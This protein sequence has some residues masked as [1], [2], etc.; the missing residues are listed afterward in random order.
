[1]MDWHGARLLAVNCMALM[2]TGLV[3]KAIDPM[4]TVMLTIY[5]CSPN[6]ETYGG[7]ATA[8]AG[9]VTNSGQPDTPGCDIGLRDEIELMANDAM[10]L[11]LSASFLAGVLTDRI[12]DTAPPASI[13]RFGCLLW[14]LGWINIFTKKLPLIFMGSLF[15]GFAFPLILNAI[16]FV[17]ATQ[18]SP[19]VG[20]SILSTSADS[21]TALPLSLSKV[22]LRLPFTSES[23]R[24]FLILGGTIAAAVSAMLTICFGT[25]DRNNVEFVED[26]MESRLSSTNPYFG[27]TESA[28][29]RTT[30]GTILSGMFSKRFTGSS[31]SKRSSTRLQSRLQRRPS[32]YE[33][34]VDSELRFTGTRTINSTGATTGGVKRRASYG[35]TTVA[36]IKQC[37][38]ASVVAAPTSCG[39]VGS[40]LNNEVTG[41]QQ[42][43]TQDRQIAGET[44]VDDIS[45]G[46]GVLID[47]DKKNTTYC[48]SSITSNETIRDRTADYYITGGGHDDNTSSN[49]SY[50]VT[51]NSNSKL[52]N[53]HT[54]VIAT[55]GDGFGYVSQESLERTTTNRQL[56]QR[57]QNSHISSCSSN[58]SSKTPQPYYYSNDSAS[59]NRDHT[60]IPTTPSTSTGELR[61]QNHSQRVV[62]S[63]GG[64]TF[65]PESLVDDDH[66]L[67]ENELR[68]LERVVLTPHENTET[69]ASKMKSPCYW[70][71]AISFSFNILRMTHVLC[72]NRA[73]LEAA[74]GYLAGDDYSGITYSMNLHNGLMVIAFIPGFMWGKLSSKIGI[75]STN[76]ILHVVGI[77]GTFFTTLP[78]QHW[79]RFGIL[80][81]IV[82]QSFI[83]SSMFCYL[84]DVFG[85]KDLVS[86]D[87]FLGLMAVPVTGLVPV[88]SRFVI[89]VID[90]DWVL[91]GRI[92]SVAGFGVLIIV[93]SLIELIRRRQRRIALMDYKG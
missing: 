67:L 91:A 61:D 22:L 76:C 78:V 40:V 83:F 69:L 81:S 88:W 50:G 17:T 47:G 92:I 19:S 56:Q 72:W 36:D 16:L 29:I 60:N 64:R 52:V 46:Y 48:S 8:A 14:C 86:L 84:S 3:V 38:T 73:T 28:R 6:G 26:F 10:V 23:A 89:H 43:W 75:S 11:G 21:S 27:C 12:I 37:G 66:V 90:S 30:S 5:G 74:N 35:S 63:T 53:E 1:M 41:I 62:A 82:H 9:G 4:R 25:L 79:Q 15:L 33:C 49:S 24:I 65:V 34:L 42:I 2:L 7:A 51:N 87:G 32:S 70:L 44:Q 20:V 58:I 85:F 57:Q 45:S 93:V 55:A 18:R 54:G 80:C 39:T 71:F 77:C 68:Y 31:C 13:V 59:G